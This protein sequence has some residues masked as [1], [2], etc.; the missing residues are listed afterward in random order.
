[1]PTQG[2][3]R[4][5]PL[6]FH[7]QYV[8]LD[9][10]TRLLIARQDMSRRRTVAMIENRDQWDRFVAAIE[11]GADEVAAVHAIDDADDA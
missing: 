11:S 9:M 7:Q 8:L 2:S 10:G 1:M 6:T 5:T 4:A 3:T